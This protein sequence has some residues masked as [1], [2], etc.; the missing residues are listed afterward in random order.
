MCRA[1]HIQ[2]LVR[3]AVS[4]LMCR[5]AEA[6]VA[7]SMGLL[8][9]EQSALGLLIPSMPQCRKDSTDRKGWSIPNS[10]NSEC[11]TQNTQ[12]YS[13]LYHKGHSINSL[14]LSAFHQPENLGEG[15]AQ[16]HLSHMLQEMLQILKKLLVNGSH[17]LH[18]RLYFIQ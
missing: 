7:Q 9:L 8:G 11:R 14:S 15:L 13:Q 17:L 5:S 4:L 2:C 10:R 1:G 16:R 18:S 12:I 6:T 3:L